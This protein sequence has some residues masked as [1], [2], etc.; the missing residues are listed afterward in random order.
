MRAV[1]VGATAG[2]GRCLAEA[3]ATNGAGLLLV[4][5]DRRD[6]DV[7]AGHLRLVF[8]VEVNVLEI[9]ARHVEASVNRIVEAANVF[10][11]V[12]SLFFPIG[13]S[14]DDDIGCLSVCDSLALINVNFSIVVGVV[15]RLIGQ[16]VK[17][18]SSNIVGFGSVAAVRGRSSN[19]V[20]AA[21]KRGLQG[22]FES[23]R[24][25][26]GGSTTSVQFYK[27]GY[28]DSQQSYGR[29]LLFPKVKPEIVAR[30]VVNNLGK[31]LGDVFFP[32]FWRFVVLAVLMLPW[33]VFR[34]LKF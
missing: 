6:L 28:I 9:D 34:R 26:T 30:Q 20:Y 14:R 4:S 8:D 1:I 13:L 33:T 25:L 11:A 27:L 23:L 16:L 31:D 32:R 29:G 3:L 12:D 21:S 2:V 7:L 17:H 18:D 24:H 15:S 5:S 10:G 22:Y 19:V